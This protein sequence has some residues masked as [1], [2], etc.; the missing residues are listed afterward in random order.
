MPKINNIEFLT[1]P[2]Q[3]MK[4]KRD[5]ATLKTAAKGDKGDTGPQGPKGDKGDKGDRGE[6]GLAGAGNGI[7]FTPF[8]LVDPY[9][10][11]SLGFT[12]SLY[13]LP[14]RSD[15]CGVTFS[16]NTHWI[17]NAVL[18]ILVNNDEGIKHL[19]VMDDEGVTSMIEEDGYSKYI[20]VE[21]AGL[22]IG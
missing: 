6:R 9:E 19:V 18:I 17:N 15:T 5:V 11:S 12:E 10:T 22:V 4:N 8:T 1:L 21:G 14:S 20:K 16:G 13:I 7:G 2:Q 3:V